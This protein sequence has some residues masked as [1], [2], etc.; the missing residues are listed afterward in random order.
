MRPL[1]PSVLALALS[2]A[3]A[4]AGN[5]AAPEGRVLVTLAG[6]LPQ[7]NTTPLKPKA[8]NISGFMDISYDKAVA[9]DEAMLAG[10]A[11]HEIDAQ[12]LD[13]AAPVTYSG[14]RLSDVMASAGAE[15]RMA[16]PMALDG[17]T[18]EIPWELITT[19]EPILATHANGVPLE[20]GKLGPA[21]VVFPVV[22][23]AELYDSFHAKE[24]FATFFI[25][26]E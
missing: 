8:V 7:A 22:A 20:I 23:D 2:A 12:I 15:G 5:M 9:F 19:H 24:V 6:D 1:I 25:G 10:L 3:T 26:V 21:M 17:F 13:S 11:Q 4:F 14:P 16:M 18:A